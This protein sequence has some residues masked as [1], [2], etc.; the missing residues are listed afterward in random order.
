MNYEDRKE[1]GWSSHR[2]GSSGFP[3]IV[4]IIDDKVC[5]KFSQYTEIQDEHGAWQEHELP[6]EIFATSIPFIVVL[7]QIMTEAETVQVPDWRDDVSVFSWRGVAVDGHVGVTTFNYRIGKHEQPPDLDDLFV[8]ITDLSAPESKVRTAMFR[9]EPL[10]RG[11]YQFF[12]N[13]WRGDY[14]HYE[15]LDRIKEQVPRCSTLSSSN[16]QGES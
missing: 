7:S 16:N 12:L 2:N 6:S 9:I 10:T 5:V 4:N 15:V 14:V 3:F 13:S 1:Q 8:A 11:V